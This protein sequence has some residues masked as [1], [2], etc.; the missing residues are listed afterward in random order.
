MNTE[1]KQSQFSIDVL[2][3][4]IIHVFWKTPL[5]SKLVEDKQ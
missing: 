3:L 5:L 4:L 1:L 2:V